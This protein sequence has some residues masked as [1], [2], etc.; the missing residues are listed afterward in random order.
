MEQTVVKTLV[1]P[2]TL[3]EALKA[4]QQVLEHVA[5][6]DFDEDA[7]FAIRLALDEAI[8]NAIQH[9]NDG[10]PAKQ[11]TVRYTIDGD[12]VR[13]EVGDEGNG[14]A[15]TGVPDPTRPENL[16]KPNGRGIMLIRAYMTEVEYNQKGNRVT[17]IKRRGCMLP[18]RQ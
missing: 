6:H 10:D 14:F 18:L 15:P 12:A 11:V 17:M 2:S 9:G 13:V 8:S 1:F 16:E 7:C 3:D 4:E 5:R